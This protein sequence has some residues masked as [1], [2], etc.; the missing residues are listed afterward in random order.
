[1]AVFAEWKFELLPCLTD[2]DTLLLGTFIVDALSYVEID[3]PY[4]Y[5]FIKSALRLRVLEELVADKFAACIPNYATF[6]L[7]KCDV[8]AALS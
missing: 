4:R 7:S 6:E 3:G 1:M 8:S 5:A 2:D